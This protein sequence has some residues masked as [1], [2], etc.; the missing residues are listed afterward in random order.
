MVPREGECGALAIEQESGK[1]KV[2]EVP[3]V[4]HEGGRRALPSRAVFHG[5]AAQVEFESKL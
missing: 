5:V 3:Y 2:V 4:F 1:W